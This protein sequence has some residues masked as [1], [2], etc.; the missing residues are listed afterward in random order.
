MAV[1]QFVR[2]NKD[3][4]LLLLGVVE[5]GE[6]A[7]YTVNLSAFRKIGIPSTG[8]ELD[9]GQMEIIRHTDTLLKAKKKALNILSYADNNKRNLSLKLYRAGF[10]REIVEEVVSEMI[11]LGYINETRQLERIILNEANV[12]LRGPRR[13]VPALASKGY[14]VGEIKEVMSDLVSSGEI[15]FA[16]NSQKLIDKKLPGVTHGEEVK[17]LLYKNGF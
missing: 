12:K 14:S 6:S 9:D 13:I 17:K 4:N 3:S 15:D 10:A 16:L 5:E 2:E 8:D 11:S 7:R 1:L